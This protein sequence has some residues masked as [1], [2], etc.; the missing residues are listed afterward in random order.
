M[1]EH[2]IHN[3]KIRGSNPA[4]HKS[5]YNEFVGDFCSDEAVNHVEGDGVGQ[6]E[7]GVG[8]GVISGQG[9]Q[10]ERKDRT[11]DAGTLQGQ[12]S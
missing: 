1:V 10:Q 7:V 8:G 4:R 6:V 11:D 12:E 3:S 9:D 2:F 5:T